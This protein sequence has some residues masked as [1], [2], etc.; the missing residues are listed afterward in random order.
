MIYANGDIYEGEWHEGKR[1]GDGVM[2]KRNGDHFE[3]Q[4]VDDL[5]EGQGSYFYSG[6]N[7]LFVGEWVADQPK[8]GVY[9]ELVDPC[10]MFSSSRR[11]TERA[12]SSKLMSSSS[13]FLPQLRSSSSII[14][15]ASIDSDRQPNWW[16][17][18]KTSRSPSSGAISPAA[19]TRPVASVVPS[20]TVKPMRN[21]P[22]A[23]AVKSNDVVPSTTVAV[24]VVRVATHP[25]DGTTP[26]VYVGRDCADLSHC[27]RRRR[28]RS[29][30]TYEISRTFRDSCWSMPIVSSSRP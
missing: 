27:T 1:N 3:G 5:R 9:T 15:A 19:V 25:P 11:A 10:S 8:C 21:V 14:S 29:R 24:A 13:P 7:K 30:I 16:T 4:W 26:P 17:G 22:A 2:A 18:P 23:A 28:D 6:K 20:V 12:N